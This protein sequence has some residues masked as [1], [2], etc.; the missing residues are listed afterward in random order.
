MSEEFQESEI[1]FSDEY[2]TKN[3]KRK[4]EN[5]KDKTTRA[6]EKISSPVRIPSRTIF[7]C[8][9]EMEEDG[10]MTP[11]HVIMG[12]RRTEMQMAFSFCSLKGRDL[13]RHRNS[14]L[15]MTGFLEV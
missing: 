11:P 4:N 7:R 3:D 9:E 13:R 8:T 10:E 1:I 15:R 14:V 5:K 12:K 2:F 6:T